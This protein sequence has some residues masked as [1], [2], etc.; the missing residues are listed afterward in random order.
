MGIEPTWGRANDPTTALKAAGPTRRPDT[1]PATRRAAHRPRLVR[2]DSI[3]PQRQIN[4][5][6]ES[7]TPDAAGRNGV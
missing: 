6:P 1:P 4:A 2:A 7:L 3:T 5:T